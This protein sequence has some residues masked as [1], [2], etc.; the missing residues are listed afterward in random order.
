MSNGISDNLFDD[1][2]RETGYLSL[3]R[4]LFNYRLRKWKISKH[5]PPSGLILDVGSGVAPASPDLKRTVLADISDEAMRSIDLPVKEK[6]VMSVTDMSFEKGSFDCV[7]CSEVL[8]HVEDDTKAIS[9]LRRVLKA[10]GTLVITVPFQKKYWGEDDDYVGH[11]RRYEP[12]ELEEKLKKAGF[13]VVKTFR[14][15]GPIERFLTLSSLRYYVKSGP[16]RKSSIGIYRIANIMIFVLLLLAESHVSWGR[17]T[18]ILTVAKELE[19]S[20]GKR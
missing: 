12:G 13:S 3:K 18:R 11:V 2:Y 9:E 10:G 5:V 7:L 20:M 4:S 17:T 14:L 19:C 16:F 1:L 6:L 8:E 15:S